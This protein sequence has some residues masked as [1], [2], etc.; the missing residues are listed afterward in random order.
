MGLEIG[1]SDV[2]QVPVEIGDEGDSSVLHEKENGTLQGPRSDEP[3][4]FGSHGNDEPVRAKEDNNVLDSN[5]PKDVADEWPKSMQ[6]H[7]FYFIRYRSYDD[8]KLRAKLDL[9]DKEIQKKNQARFQIMEA[10]KAK[11]TDRAQVISQLKL[12]TAEDKQYRMI[13][14]EKR[15]EMEPLQQALGKLRTSNNS[16]ERG[17]VICSSEEELDDL[18]HSLHY[19][20]QHESIPLSEEK[21]LLREIKQLEGTREKV[22]AN[23]AMR[24]KIQDSLGQ[25][26]TIQDQVKLIGGDLDGVRKEKGAVRAKIKQ[27]EEELKVVDTDI[28]ALQEELT[29][30]IQ[31]R[32]KAYETLRELR[33]HRDEGNAYFYQNR[34]LLNEVRELAAK[35]DIHAVEERSHQEVEKF[36][37]LWNTNKAFR[38]DYEKR[39]LPSLDSRQLSRDGRMRNPDEKPL[40]TEAAQPVTPTETDA[41]PKVNVKKPK[42]ESKVPPE[43]D[44]KLT[45]KEKKEVKSPPV[46]ITMEHTGIKEEEKN[47]D[48]VSELEKLP[49]EMETPVKNEVDE[50]KLKEMKR[51][52]EIAKAKMAI[53]RKKKLAEKAAAKAAIRAQ[54]EAEKK[55]KEREKKAKKKAAASS[56]AIDP[57]EQIEA[58]VKENEVKGTKEEADTPIETTASLKTKEPKETPVRYRNR[59]R[60]VSSISKV[61]IKRRKQTNYWVWAIPSALL[62][63]LFLVLGYQYFLLK[64]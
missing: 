12:L 57:E 40:V 48:K 43:N 18:I 26:E 34:S 11:R 9:A 4:K 28:N 17:G 6:T 36:M 52:E 8:P 45:Q 58:D 64:N 3:I 7:S 24:A 53:E 59:P 25:K 42:E 51:E 21:Q 47:D 35:K 27:L 29:A 14:D 49:K 39:I 50:A 15:R 23:A 5:Y 37:S 54:K 31:K 16:R 62:V 46:A 56:P 61:A 44:T 55:L 33:K 63:V 30:V 19:R 41:A 38:D 10:L 13:V 22:I 32:D 60:G 1:E 2:V 20:M